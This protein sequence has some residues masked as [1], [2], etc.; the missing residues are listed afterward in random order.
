MLRTASDFLESSE[1][2]GFEELA[3]AFELAEALEAEAEAVAAAV[4]AASGEAEG[5]ALASVAVV[6]AVCD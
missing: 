3:D 2:E 5:D 1:A 4:A 6:C